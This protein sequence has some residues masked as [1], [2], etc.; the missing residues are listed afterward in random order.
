VSRVTSMYAMFSNAVVFEQPL[1]TWNV[2]INTNIT[3]IFDDAGCK[4]SADLPISCFLRCFN[5]TSEL[6]GVFDFYLV[7]DSTGS[8]VAS[9][10]GHPIGNWCVSKIQDFSFLFFP[11][12]PHAF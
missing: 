10:Y 3:S 7:D 12:L 4:V 11:H 9:M 6:R 8:R 2:S 1:L 5:T